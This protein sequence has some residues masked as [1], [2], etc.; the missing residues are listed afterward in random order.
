MRTLRLSLCFE[1]IDFLT[2]SANPL[3]G[4]HAFLLLPLLKSVINGLGFCILI[5]NSNP[6]E[7][8]LQVCRRSDTTNRLMIMTTNQRTT[9]W[10]LRA[11]H[12]HTTF[13]NRKWVAILTVIPM[14]SAF[15]VM[16]HGSIHS[17]F[18]FIAHWHIE[19]R[20]AQHLLNVLNFISHACCLA[21]V[22]STYI[23]CE[24]KVSPGLVQELSKL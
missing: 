5:S 13:S 19:C 23:V 6:A 11:F 22:F 7:L 10:A 14:A 15:K 20:I 9:L 1:V 17:C 21:G 4:S 12:R 3:P 18:F 2:H 24:L 16:C 8:T